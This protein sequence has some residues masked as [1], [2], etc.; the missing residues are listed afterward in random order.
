[1]HVVDGVVQTG[2]APAA[3]TP[4]PTPPAAFRPAA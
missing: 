3:A 2:G 4:E 1:M